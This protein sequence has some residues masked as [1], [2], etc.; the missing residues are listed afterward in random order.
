MKCFYSIFAVW[1]LLV[2]SL[3]RNGGF[4]AAEVRG[5][6]LDAMNED[7]DG[8]AVVEGR[9]LM[10]SYESTGMK[11][12]DYGRTPFSYGY[13]PMKTVFNGKGA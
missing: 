9:Q 4:V 7:L 5:A 3:L 12:M 13:K 2:P 8:A 6:Q 11:S 1:V 10:Y